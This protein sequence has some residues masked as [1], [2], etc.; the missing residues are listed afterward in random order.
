M[1]KRIN[2][3]IESYTITFKDNLKSKIVELDIQEKSKVND[4][5]EYIYDYERLVIQKDELSKKKR[6]KNKIPSPNRCIAKRADGD[7]CT[8]RKKEGCEFCGTH[9]KG[10]PLGLFKNLDNKENNEK[11]E[12]FVEE[13]RG[14]V[15]Y[16]DKYNNVY[17]TE[18]ILEG[19]ENPKI[20]AKCVKDNGV[21]TIPELGLF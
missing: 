19:V 21:C 11:I 4:L 14:I 16:I 17:K 13:I 3:Y 7:Q 9:S 5:L 6:S 8:R 15:Y 20:I 12:V 2:K 1:E 18:D 10:T